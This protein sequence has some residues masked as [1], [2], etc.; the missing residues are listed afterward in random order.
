MVEQALRARVEMSPRPVQQAPFRVL[1][2]ASMPAVLVEIGY[3]SN[4]EQEQALTSAAYQDLVAQGLFD[5]IVQFRSHLE[6]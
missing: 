5:A 4:S 2:G 6:R 3:L 1:V